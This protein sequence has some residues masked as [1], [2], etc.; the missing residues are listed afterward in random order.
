MVLC[1]RK[2]YP[3]ARFLSRKLPGVTE[4]VLQHH[5]QQL[6]IPV[7][8]DMTYVKKLFGP[9]QRL[10]GATEFPGIGIGLATVK[11]IIG[12][13]GGVVWAEGTQGQGATFYFTL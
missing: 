1:D 2:F 3:G 10:H 13:H 9:F 6:L 12:R 5:S 4:Q 11:R 7:G 8:F